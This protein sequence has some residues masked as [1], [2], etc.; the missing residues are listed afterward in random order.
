MR[1]KSP[2]HSIMRTRLRVYG[3]ILVTAPLWCLIAAM[4]I[5]G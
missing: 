3:I 2:G 1:T 5:G 4:M